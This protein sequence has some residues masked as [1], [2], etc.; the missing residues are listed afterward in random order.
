MDNWYKDAVRCEHNSTYLAWVLH[1]GRFV[2]VIKCNGCT[3][4]M[5][6]P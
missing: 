2:S 4:T 5:R 6:E 3:L 1:V